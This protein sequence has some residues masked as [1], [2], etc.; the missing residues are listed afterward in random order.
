ML[1]MTDPLVT[2]FEKEAPEK[3]YP[4]EFANDILVKSFIKEIE[5]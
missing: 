4:D 2:Q 5:E 3:V 1:L